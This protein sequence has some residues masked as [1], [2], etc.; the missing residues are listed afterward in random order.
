MSFGNLGIIAQMG[1]PRTSPGAIITIA[2][3]DAS[4]KSKR[5]ADV[6]CTGIDDD[7]V[8]QSAIDSL[9]TGGIIHLTEG[10]FNVS[11]VMRIGDKITLRGSGIG[12]TT[13]KVSGNK[14]ITQSVFPINNINAA[15]IH[16]FTFDG[17]NIIRIGSSNEVNFSWGGSGNQ[18]NPQFFKIFDLHIKNCSEGVRFSDGGGNKGSL[19]IYNILFE[20]LKGTSIITETLNAPNICSF[21]FIS[22]C[23][24]KNSRENG[25]GITAWGDYPYKNFV[26]IDK[27]FMDG[28]IFV[29]PKPRV[30]ITN[31]DCLKIEMQSNE[32]LVTG[33]ITKEGIVDSSGKEGNQIYN[34]YIRP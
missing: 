29:E 32:C 23:T 8:I 10:I 7:L 3:S 21:V 15:S 13:I 26:W 28:K 12:A 34:N 18:S 22:S 9:N 17:N 1:L 5:G 25:G 4:A 6:I 16:G 2:A 31:C 14:N 19:F 27:V 24:M 20:S 33:N 30:T 11:G